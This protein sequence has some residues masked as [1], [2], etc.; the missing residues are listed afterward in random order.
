MVQ[1]TAPSSDG[2]AEDSVRETPI[3]NNL[4]K[5]RGITQMQ[6]IWALPANK[7]LV[8]G[9]NGSRQPVGESGQTFKGGW[10]PYASATTIAHLCQV[11]GRM[12]TVNTKKKPGQ[13]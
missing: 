11:I 8:C 1:E 4:N 9:L 5:K 7:K 3:S 13:R 6:R 10:A 2:R 12:S